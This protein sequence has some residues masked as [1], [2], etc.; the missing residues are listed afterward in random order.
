[1]QIFNALKN[2]MRF[3]QVQKS[4][5]ATQ[6]ELLLVALWTQIMNQTIRLRL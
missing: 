3:K 4:D 5:L 2:K 1:M 6:K